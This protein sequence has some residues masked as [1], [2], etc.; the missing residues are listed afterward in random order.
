MCKL[1]HLIPPCLSVPCV[2]VGIN[3]TGLG[4]H[5]S[6]RPQ[7]WTTSG[8]ATVVRLACIGYYGRWRQSRRHS[9]VQ[10]KHGQLCQPGACV[11]VIPTPSQIPRLPS[12]E[13]GLIHWLIHW[14]IDSLTH[15]LIDSLI[16]W[17]FIDWFIDSFIWFVAHYVLKIRAR[18]H[19]TPLWLFVR[20]MNWPQNLLTRTCRYCTVHAKM[21]EL[22]HLLLLRLLLAVHTL[23]ASF[24]LSH[25]FP[26]LFTLPYPILSSP[27][28]SP[29]PPSHL[30]LSPSL[31]NPSLFLSFLPFPLPATPY[32]VTCPYSVFSSSLLP[33]SPSPPPPPP[34]PL[35]SPPPP[36]I[37]PPPIPPPPPRLSLLVD[38]V[39]IL[40]H[41]RLSCFSD[42][43]H[44]WSA[45]SFC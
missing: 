2:T 14:F 32:L 42:C 31:A 17:L 43:P 20:L 7:R 11:P 33:S 34:S 45:V 36:P 23:V 10:S 25:P 5:H 44:V 6:L 12:G 16:Y 22:I 19:S 8:Q 9:G 37:P 3:P 30:S 35:S 13:D 41:K 1:F 39:G 29:P 27:L 4:K 26:L 18:L 38:F 28:P 21:S 15:W 40:F 24:V